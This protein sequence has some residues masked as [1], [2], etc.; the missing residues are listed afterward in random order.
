MTEPLSDQI[1]QKVKQASELYH[2]LVLVVAPTGEGKTAALQNVKNRIGA[3]MINVNLELSRRMLDLTE[4]QRALR[5]PQILGEIVSRESADMILL[6]NT[7]II[8]DVVMK[9]DPLRLLQG[10]SRSQTVVAS[11]S[12]AIGENS[13]TYAI[14]DH[15]EY[16]R[17]PLRDFLFVSTRPTLET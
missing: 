14:P 8:F 13:L 2:R 5:L 6:D 11:W 4:R 1:V 16:R 15:P 3:P 7:E 17:Y 9:Q 10:L 12:G